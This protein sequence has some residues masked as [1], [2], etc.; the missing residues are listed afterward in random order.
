MIAPPPVI[1]DYS[2]VNLAVP[3]AVE[4]CIEAVVM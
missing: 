2:T 4:A 1:L 3:N